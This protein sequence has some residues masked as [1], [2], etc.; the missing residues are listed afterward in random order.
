MNAF[1]SAHRVEQT[2]DATHWCLTGGKYNV[3][4]DVQLFWKLYANAR[5]PLRL[6]ERALY[7]S[8]FFMDIDKYSQPV[9]ELIRDVR[10][11]YPTVVTC[12]C[13][14]GGGIHFIFPDIIVSTPEEACSICTRMCD[15]FPSL[16]PHVD[17]S[18]YRSGLRMI[19]SY[20]SLSV[21]RRYYNAS[22]NVSVSELQACS[23]HHGVNGRPPVATLKVSSPS[24]AKMSGGIH[25]DFS[26]L[27][28]M[29][30][31]LSIKAVLWTRTERFYALLSDS[32]FCQNIMR[33]HRSR[34]AYFVVDV[35]KKEV[36]QRCLCKCADKTC[37]TFMS[38]KVKIGIKDYYRIKD[39]VKEIDRIATNGV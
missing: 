18:V 29:Y 28:Q 6:V 20:K 26:A 10:L 25:V 8:R 30:K 32:R 17:R 16:L 13:E 24:I 34:R 14:E 19:G 35:R 12:V 11:K 36:L 9:T 27:D 7:P 2:N 37:S 5:H 21:R 4:P 23:I 38:R 22:S 33:E 39:Y 31:Y 3:R 1:L 15:Q